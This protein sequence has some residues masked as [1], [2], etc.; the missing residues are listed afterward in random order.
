M[1]NENKEH[2][3]YL[4]VDADCDITF[5]LFDSDQ[6]FHG[7]C[8]SLSGAG[9]FFTAEQA[10]EMGKGL[11]IN[12]PAQKHMV[13]AMTAFIEVVRSTAT[14]DGRF[15]IAASIKSIKAN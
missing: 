2:R 10:V 3:N 4:R 9:I 11:E 5:K 1:L 15:E 12:I 6:L 7:K 13:P 8:T 14:D